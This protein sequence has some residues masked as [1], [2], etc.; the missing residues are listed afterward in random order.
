MSDRPVLRWLMQPRHWWIPLL[1]IFLISAAGVSWIVHEA[2][3]DAPPIADMVGPDGT[4]VVRG[5]VIRDGQEVFLKHALMEYGSMFGDGAGRGPDFSAEALHL[6]AGFM[7]EHYADA[8]ERAQ[9]APPDPDEQLAIA[10]RVKRE[11][12]GSAY[13]PAA[14]VVPLTAA[15]VSAVERLRAF[16]VDR[17]T[18]LARSGSFPPPGF[19]ADPVALRALSDFFFWGGWVCAAQRPGETFS[20]THNWPYDPEAGNL[21]TGPVLWWSVV[22]VLIFILALGAV[23][24]AYGQFDGLKEE[25]LTAGATG[26]M[27]AAS[28][29]DF[30]PGPLQRAT[31][32]FFL[33]AALVF[34]V[35]VLSGAIT[36]TSFAD[37]LG[38]VGIDLSGILPLVVSRSWHLSLA[39]FWISACWIGISIFLIPMI[40]RETAGLVRWTNVLFWAIVVLVAGTVVG[41]Y[42]GPLGLLGGQWSMLGHQGWEFVEFGRLFQGL[43]LAVLVAW[44]GILYA[45]CKPA[46]RKGRPWALP[47]WL[48]Y[49]TVC[50]S[51]LLLS[52]FVSTPRTNFVIADLWRWAVIHMWVEA[53]FEVFTTIVVGWLMVRMGLVGQASVTRVV[54]LATLLFL[55]SGLLGISHNF[56]WNAKPVATMALGSVFSTLQVV[57]LILLTLEAWRFNRM[58]RDRTTPAGAF[59][60]PEVFLFLVAVNFWNFFGAGVLGLIINLPIVNYYEHGT[61]LTVN[62]GHAALFGVYGNLS[63]A[64]LLFCCKLLME[65]EAWHG[66]TVRTAFWSLNI[67]L[68][69][70]VVMD[71]FPAGLVQLQ[72]VLEHGFWY[73]RSE[74]FIGSPVFEGLT[75]LRGIGATLFILGGVFPI[76]W[77]VLQGTLRLKRSRTT[78][79]Q[80]VEPALVED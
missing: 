18:V 62:H 54:Y 8:L 30:K 9:G 56:Y 6:T 20:Y 64:A 5:E 70:M 60:Q 51:L 15:Q 48:V 37:Y 32:K 4:V 14:G 2:Y 68:L 26:R 39:L 63:L 79:E 73:A 58:R 76:A 35:Q 55:G 27:D 80:V 34:V 29:R 75:W 47:N 52:G 69:L 11:L 77:V 10:E 57:P 40:G 19:I 53:F 38:A 21:P 71:L 65:P 45:G 74:R 24:F 28:V 3:H 44:A 46:F 59:G 50:I 33:A 72:A 49:S 16:T 7:R 25:S 36:I 66:R 42:A 78:Q 43:L 12:K 17:F 13:D 61:Y 22:G 41:S 31:F 67:G 23:L 1:A